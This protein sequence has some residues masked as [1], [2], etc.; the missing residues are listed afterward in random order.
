MRLLLDQ[1]LSYRLKETLRDVFP[2]TLHVRDAGLESA[3]DLAV[4][5]YA[6]TNSL[7]LVSKDSDFRQLSFT[8]GHPPKIVWVRRG[9]CTT[10]EIA[11][12]LRDN[13]EDLF[14]FNLDEEGSFLAIS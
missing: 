14:A 5:E 13:Y 2:D 9:N 8:F 6:K 7:V 1:N 10:S 11:R 4:W 12:I 3:D